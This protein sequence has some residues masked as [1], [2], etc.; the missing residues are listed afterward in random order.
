M[1]PAL[2]KIKEEGGGDKKMRLLLLSTLTFVALRRNILKIE[3]R[4]GGH[5]RRGAFT[6][7]NRQRSARQ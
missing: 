6:S 7:S 5:D 3:G 1:H 4:V 2:C